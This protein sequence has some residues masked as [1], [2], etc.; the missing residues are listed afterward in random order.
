MDDEERQQLRE[1]LRAHQGRLRVLDLQAAQFGINLPPHVATEIEHIRTEMIRVRTALDATTPP[2][3]RVALRQLRQQAW[4]AYYA[5]QWQR[6]EELLTQALAADPDD[7]DMRVTLARVQQQLDL[8]AFYQ[9]ICDLRDE[10]LWQAV[11][12]ALD[13]LD[14]R[15]AGYPDPQGLRD[16]AHRRQQREQL[17]ADA[18]LAHQRG[19]WDTAGQILN[20]L[21][22]E[23]P[24]DVEGHALLHEVQ[25]QQH[26]AQHVD[27]TD[28]QSDTVTDIHQKVTKRP[29][30]KST[31]LPSG[32]ASAIR[33]VPQ[34]QTGNRHAE[35]RDKRASQSTTAEKTAPGGPQQSTTLSSLFT[36]EANRVILQRP[37]RIEL[38]RIPAG[39]FL[40][41]SD[42]ARDRQ[43]REDE[44]PQHPVYVSEFYVGPETG[45]RIVVLP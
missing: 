39:E 27:V 6:A 14:R 5:K 4:K 16:W 22:R 9:T 19:D 35:Q 33:A 45:F 17:L 23:S 25:T 15:Q 7:S 3:T 26:G 2:A 13:D 28:Q 24:Q 30:L 40:M 42:P 43:A 20:V 1:L 38:V 36:T 10:G 37:I 32:D 12:A 11:L 29:K 44:L 8:Q 31:S 21:L 34:R 41:G 18:R